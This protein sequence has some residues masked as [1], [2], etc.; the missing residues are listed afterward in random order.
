MSGKTT[1]NVQ[2]ARNERRLIEW[3]AINSLKPSG[4]YMYYLI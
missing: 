4:N 3:E 2:P 1:H